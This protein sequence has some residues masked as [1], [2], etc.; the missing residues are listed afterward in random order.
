[1]KINVDNEI[2]LKILKNTNEKDLFKITHCSRNHLREWLPW[3][4]Y[5]VEAKDSGEFIK[6]MNEKW[7]E[8]KALALGIFYHEKIVGIVSF[9]EINH[10]ND[11]AEIGYWITKDYT[12]KGITTR[13]VKKLI[14]YGFKELELN[15]IEILTAT[16]NFNSQNV[17][18]KLSFI[19]EGV[20]RSAEKLHN[21][22]Q[23]IQTFGILKSEWEEMKRSKK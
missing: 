21:K 18:K 6:I 15:K 23:D 22:Y 11:I 2:I 9:N 4:D 17:A 10:T 19:K 3:V 7:E 14:D 20:R 13:S 8:K 16:K 1:M 12:N 5:I